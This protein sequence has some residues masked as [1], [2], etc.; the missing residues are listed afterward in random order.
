MAASWADGDGNAV[1]RAWLR[2]AVL[3]DPPMQERFRPPTRGAKGDGDEA[4]GQY[5]SQSVHACSVLEKGPGIGREKHDYGMNERGYD[6]V[7]DR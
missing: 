4:E 2:R 1:Y 6:G 3:G 7:S 5:T